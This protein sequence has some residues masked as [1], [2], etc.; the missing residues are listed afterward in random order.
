VGATPLILPEILGQNLRFARSQ[1]YAKKL[2]AKAKFA[3]NCTPQDRDF[4]QALNGILHQY[5][6]GKSVSVVTPCKSFQLVQAHC[7]CIMSVA[8]MQADCD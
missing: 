2:R 8:R 7:Q 5:Y 3:K 4:L 1:I 6:S